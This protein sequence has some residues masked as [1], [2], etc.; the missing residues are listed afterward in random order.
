[1]RHRM[2][3]NFAAHAEGVSADDIVKR[4]LDSI[5]FE[6]RLYDVPSKRRETAG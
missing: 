5:P 2:G 6:E 4:L 3:V 1:M